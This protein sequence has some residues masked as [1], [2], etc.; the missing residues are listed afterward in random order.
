[1][2]NF[3]KVPELYDCAQCKR[4]L[5]VKDYKIST[6][7][8]PASET[9]HIH[10]SPNHFPFIVCCSCGHYTVVVDELPYKQ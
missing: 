7:P 9:V 5:T 4:H 6:R 1:M 10:F 2:K 8:D 3:K